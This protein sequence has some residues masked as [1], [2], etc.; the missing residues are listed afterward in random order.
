MSKWPGK[1][2]IGLTGNIATGKSV[3]R[4][5]LE[6]LGAYG[7]DADALGHRA[8]SKGAP[9]YAQVL[10]LFGKWVLDPDGQINRGRLGRIVF[11]DPEA[12]A[13]LE[14]IVHPLVL[15]AVDVM[16]Q[17][18]S[19]KVVVVEAIKLLE[20]NMHKTCDSIWVSVASP[21]A[22]VARLKQQRGMAENEARQRLKVQPPQENK[23]AAANIII[24]NNGTFTDT[25]RQVSAAWQKVVP[26]AAEPAPAPAPAAPRG[27]WTVERGRP[28]HSTEIAVFISRVTRGQRHFTTEEIMAAFGEKA[29]LLLQLDRRLV[30]VV[31]WQ[32]ENLVART[33]DVFLDPSIPI[34]KAM[35]SLLSEMEKASRD[36]QCEASLLYLPANLAQADAT[37]KQLGY[38]RRSAETL[39]IQAWQE[40][41]KES[42]VPGAILFFKQLRQDRILRPI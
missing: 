23:A 31:G 30:G 13:R 37:W 35:P 14:A 9:G 33:T 4:K 6:H 42:N 8:I 25:W 5:M 27:E 22:Q 29:F 39:T 26:M 12:L 7:I 11:A 10:D 19:Q 24:K 15:Q 34:A 17:R 20:A 38:E 41:A 21:E 2:V 28:K 16:I 1:Y 18:S 32:V 3:V 36:L 40:A